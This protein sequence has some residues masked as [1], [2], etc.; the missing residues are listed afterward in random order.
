MN[1]EES[2]PLDG[3]WAQECCSIY[4]DQL[5]EGILSGCIYREGCIELK[6]VIVSNPNLSTLAIKAVL[7]DGIPDVLQDSSLVKPG[8]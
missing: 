3:S 1:I 4:K 2:C 8:C 5:A 7:I 6:G